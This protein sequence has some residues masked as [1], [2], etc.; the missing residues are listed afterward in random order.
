VLAVVVDH[1]RQQLPGRKVE[2][3]IPERMPVLI[4]DDLRFED[5]SGPRASVVANA[6][7]RELPISGVP[8]WR[9][10]WAYARALVPWLD[11]LQRHGVDPF[12]DRDELRA[13]LAAPRTAKRYVRDLRS[14]SPV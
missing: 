11:F 5:A 12:G 9:S 4:D 3:L 7:L 10:W 14:S 2:P 1:P 8:A 6:W 13:V